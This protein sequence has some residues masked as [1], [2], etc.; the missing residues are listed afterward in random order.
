[1]RTQGPAAILLTLFLGLATMGTAQPVADPPASGPWTLEDCLLYG[2]SHHPSIRS[3]AGAVDGARA[4]LGTARSNLGTKMTAQGSFSRRRTEYSRA[5]ANARVAGGSDDLVDSTGESVS[6]RKVLTDFGKTATRLQSLNKD[7]RAAMA[8]RSWVEVQLGAE[9]KNA[10]L[11]ALQARAQLDV[12]R[13][14]LERFQVHL[15]KVKSFVEVGAKPPYDITKAEVDVANARVSLIGAESNFRNACSALRKTVGAPRDVEVGPADVGSRPA[16]VDLQVDRLMQEAL[17]RPDLL[18]T[19]LAIESARLR[20]KEARLGLRPSLSGSADYSWSGS[21]TPLDRGYTL[22]LSLSAP[23]LDGRQTEFSVKAAKSS[24]NV[25]ESRLE[26]ALLSLRNEVEQAVTGVI[27]AGQ[28]FEAAEILVRQ[29]SETLLLAEGRY[30]A[31]VGSPIELT[32]ARTGYTSA[33][34]SFVTAAFDERIAHATLDRVVGRFPPEMTGWGSDG[35]LPA[36]QDLPA[37]PVPASSA[38][39]VEIAPA[40]GTAEP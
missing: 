7:L 9:I 16:A 20:E 35:G 30:D 4:N 12:Q 19:R 40:S 34:G 28:R 38:A 21:V 6:V 23:F 27:D 14:N 22:G 13:E 17:S 32:D 15:G 29:A 26:Q 24:V 31:G 3:A 39:V 8:E 5:L 37:P 25:A 2:L 33:R 10:W 18:S 11:R 36:G 1:M